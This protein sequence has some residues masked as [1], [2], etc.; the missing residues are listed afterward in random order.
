MIQLL[1]VV[2]VVH[3]NFFSPN[4]LPRNGWEE[5]ATT[6]WCKTKREQFD[7]NIFTSRSVCHEF[8]V[9]WNKSWS[10]CSFWSHHQNVFT[11]FSFFFYTVRCVE[12]RNILYHHRFAPEN[13]TKIQLQRKSRKRREKREMMRLKNWGSLQRTSFR[14]KKNCRRHRWKER[15]TLPVNF[16]RD[17]FTS[18]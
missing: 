8:E 7:S 10:C 2:V 1:V 6:L 4:F 18:C 16:S 3:L 14:R 15:K 12:E 5:E 17:F 13:E 11:V 9:K